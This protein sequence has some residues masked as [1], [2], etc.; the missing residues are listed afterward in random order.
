M[1]RPASAAI[2]LC[3]FVTCTATAQDANRQTAPPPAIVKEVEQYLQK[4]GPSLQRGTEPYYAAATLEEALK[5][6]KEGNYG[7]GSVVI[8]KWKDKA[9]E[10]RGRNAMVTGYG[11]RDHAEARALERAVIY[12][13]TLRGKQLLSEPNTTPN[14]TEPD[15]SYP[16]D[17]DY[18]KS[19]T[20][21]LHIYGTLEP[22]PMCMIMML[23]AGVKSS[24][25][26]AKDGELK[27]VN[28]HE[29]SDGGA[30]ATDDKFPTNPALWQFFRDKQGLRFT[31]YDKD[32]QLADFGRRIF[33]ETRQQ[34]SDFLAKQNQVDP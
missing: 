12:L 11:L 27:M 2:L 29:I 34:I 15:R 17:T 7:I 21:G 3:C 33:L 30:T 13:A 31:L 19:L 18:L 14:T 4:L 1:L 24:Q 20:D 22:C 23:N 25:S 9:Y 28:G 8:V 26:L 16:L 6:F 10:F 5:A 32:P